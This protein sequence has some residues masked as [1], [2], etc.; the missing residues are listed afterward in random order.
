[1]LCEESD[2]QAVMTYIRARSKWLLVPIECCIHI[3]LC[4]QLRRSQVCSGVAE[5]EIVREMRALTAQ[6]LILRRRLE[7]RRNRALCICERTAARAH[8]LREAPLLVRRDLF[9]GAQIENRLNR[10]IDISRVNVLANRCIIIHPTHRSVLSNLK[11]V[12]SGGHPIR[13]G[14]QLPLPVWT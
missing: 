2:T 14:N 1:M 7:I 5:V 6:E 11:Y 4:L 10:L 12:I 8:H 9:M 13:R 3:E